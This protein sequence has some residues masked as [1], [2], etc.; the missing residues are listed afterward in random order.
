MLKSIIITTA[1]LLCMGCGSP[2]DDTQQPSEKTLLSPSTETRLCIETTSPDV[3]GAEIK[4]KG[5]IPTT[6]KNREVP[7]ARSN[8]M[9]S[10]ASFSDGELRM[11]GISYVKKEKYSVC[12]DGIQVSDLQITS[13]Y[14]IGDDYAEI[15]DSVKIVISSVRGGE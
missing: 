6:V 12:I 13:L 2:T 10:V 7:I 9:M 3:K 1:A 14:G 11:I 15:K 4:V 5:F 8:F